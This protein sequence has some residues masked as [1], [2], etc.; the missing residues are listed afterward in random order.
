MTRVSFYL[1]LASMVILSGCAALPD[2]FLGLFGGGGDGLLPAPEAVSEQTLDDSP[3]PPPPEGA[4]T[5]EEFDTTDDADRA[6]ALAVE[7]GNSGSLGVTTVTLGDIAQAGIW[8]RTPLVTELQMGRAV[9][10][11]E[12]INIELRPS[13][14]AVGSGSQMSLAAMRLLGLS[15]ADVV[16]VA[17]FVN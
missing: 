1:G 9:A 7:S 4:S 5:V 17:V 3:P 12:S 16:E 15:L 6:A 8:L 11:G 13:G 2:R 14:G 10:G